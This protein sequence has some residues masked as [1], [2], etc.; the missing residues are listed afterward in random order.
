MRIVTLP[1]VLRPPSD[2]WLLARVMRDG[3]YAP[4]ASVLDVFAGTGALAIAASTEG[5]AAVTAIDVSRRATLNIRINA[6]LNHA[7]VRVLRGDIFAPVAGE[8]FDL[9]VANPPYLPSFDDE[10]PTNGRSRAWDA[11][12]DGRALVDRMIASLADHLNPGGR[13]LIVH[14]SVT[15]EQATLDALRGRGLEATVKVRQR[16]SL[17]KLLSACAAMLAERGLLPDGADEEDMLV[18]EALHP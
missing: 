10:P 4:A 14:S 12:L 7:R 18:M 15:G 3:R 8:R 1:G 13:A 9:I 11:G 17:G 5:A 16:G 2:C 6:A